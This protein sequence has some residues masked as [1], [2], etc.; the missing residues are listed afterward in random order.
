MLARYDL[1]SLIRAI[2]PRPVTVVN[3]VDLLDHPLHASEYRGLVNAP[4]DLV[5]RGR[6]DPLPNLAVTR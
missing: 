5:V 1:D 3:P 6:H 2:A 4:A